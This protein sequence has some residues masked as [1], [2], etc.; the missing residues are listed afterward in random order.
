[1]SVTFWSELALILV[2]ITAVYVSFMRS[3]VPQVMPIAVPTRAAL[4]AVPRDRL[5]K[6]LQAL[7]FHFVGDYD[8]SMMSDITTRLRAYLS[9]DRLCAAGLIDLKTT[10]QA[11]TALEFHTQLYPSGNI[12]T[13]TSS[14]P[15]IFSYPPDKMLAQVPWKKTAAEVFE[16]HQ[17]LCETAACEKFTPAKIDSDGLADAIRTDTRRDLDYQVRNGR[18]KKI[19]PDQYRLTL[20]GA[21][22]AVPIVW[23]HMCYKGLF[24]WYKPSN[25][26]FLRRLQR[27]LQRFRLSV[28]SRENDGGR[29][30]A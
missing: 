19:A 17:M 27:R 15:R 1:M 18:F 24:F 6:E 11:V 20:F 4:P 13:S 14:H 30:K 9:H 2:G 3:T 28:R 7:G 12:T 23:F 8:V 21:I 10:G 5:E 22:I 25:R 26:I 16:L 29:T